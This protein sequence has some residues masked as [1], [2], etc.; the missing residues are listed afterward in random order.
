MIDLP[1]DL[2]GSGSIPS[3]QSHKAEIITIASGKGGVGKTLF[4]INLAIEAVAMNK[5]V[6]VLDADLGLANIHIMAGIYPEHDIMDVVD[7]KKTIKEVI[8]DGP[9]GI[10]IIPGASGIFQLSNLSHQKRQAL[11]EQLSQLETDYDVIIIDSEAGISHNVMKFTSIADRVVIVTT[12]DLTALSDAYAIIKVMRTR[13]STDFIGV[14]IN[15][16]RSL[17]EAEMVYKKIYMAAEKFLNYKLTSYGQ[18]FEDALTVK[19]SIQS[20]R[21]ISVQYPKS[22]VGGSLKTVAHTVFGVEQKRSCEPTHVLLNRFSMLL[23]N[24]RAKEPA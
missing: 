5:R 19:E 3:H 9:G 16:V 17:S 10:H 2:S 14:V 6:L 22:K 4:S 23:E 24:I 18:I 11:V 8:V 7:G 13:R 12:P 20:R 21:P 15:R 1:A